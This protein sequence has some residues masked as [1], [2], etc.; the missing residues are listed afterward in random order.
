M[1][2]MRDKTTLQ[3]LNWGQPPW[4]DQDTLTNTEVVDCNQPLPSQPQNYKFDGTQFI[5]SPVTTPT[6]TARNAIITTANSA[7]GVKLVDLTAAQIKALM[8][9]LLYAAGGVDIK[10]MAVRPLSEWLK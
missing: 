9:C 8:A 2:I 5:S 6:E 1:K 4:S 7:V 3:I 10:T